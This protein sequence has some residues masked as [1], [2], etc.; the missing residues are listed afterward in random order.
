MLITDEIRALREIVAVLE[1]ERQLS[2]FQRV[3]KTQELKDNV[4]SCTAKLDACIERFTVRR[5]NA[6]VYIFSPIF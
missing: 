3:R 5:P 2:W 6:A 4:L 1:E